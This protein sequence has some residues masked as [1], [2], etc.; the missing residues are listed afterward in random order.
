MNL[1]LQKLKL[2]STIFASSYIIWFSSCWCYSICYITVH[3]NGLARSRWWFYCGVGSIVLQFNWLRNTSSQ[4]TIWLILYWLD[5]LQ[6]YRS[7]C[8]RR[9]GGGDWLGEQNKS[10]IYTVVYK[11]NVHF[12]VFFVIDPVR[13]L[14]IQINTVI[15]TLTA[16]TTITTLITLTVTITVTFE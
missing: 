14:M 3:S 10:G 13:L 9:C 7:L 16:I 8:G 11:I 5:M 6:S 12:T 15:N 1:A 2:M 4:Y